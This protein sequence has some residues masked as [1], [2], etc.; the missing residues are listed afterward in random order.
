MAASR[1]MM[2]LVCAVSGGPLHVGDIFENRIFK[3]RYRLDDEKTST[4]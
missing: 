1:T 3:G 4:P 2:L